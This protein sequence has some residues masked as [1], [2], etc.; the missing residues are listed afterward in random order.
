MMNFK[1]KRKKDMK[2][3]ERFSRDFPE[4]VMFYFLKDI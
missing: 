1:R 3:G 4:T 2:I